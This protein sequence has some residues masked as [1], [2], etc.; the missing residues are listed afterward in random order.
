MSG[1]LKQ[2]FR[3][4]E[5]F[6]PYKRRVFEGEY[7]N[8]IAFPIGGI[9]TGCISLS[10]RGEL[11]DWEIF[12]RPNKNYRPRHTFFSLWAGR[13]GE[14]PVFRVLE[15]QL[16][17]AWSRHLMKHDAD[18]SPHHGYS[19][20]LARMSAAKF[21]GEFP[22]ALVEFEDKKVPLR[23]TLEV[24][25][26]FIPHNDR[27]SSL[28]VA[29]FFITLKNKGSKEV[30]ATVAL[31]VENMIGYQTPCCVD[32]RKISRPRPGLCVNRFR[33][34]KGLCGISMESRKF[35]PE[36]PQFGNLALGTSWKNVA[37]QA[38]WLR[39]AWFHG[40]THFCNTFVRTG[41]FDNNNE[42]SPSAENTTDIVS[43]GLRM[44]LASG[45][46]ARLPFILAWYFPRFE[47]YWKT[48]LYK[49]SCD[50]EP[51]G[52]RNYYATIFKDSWD[53][54]TYCVKNLK[55]LHD[56]SKEFSHALYN[57]TIPACAL[58]SVADN[59]SI[60]KTPTCVRLEDGSFYG[61]EGC[62]AGSGC[63]EGTCTHV[64][65]YA[66]ALP[67]LFPRLERTLRE[68]ELRY[69]VRMEDGHMQFRMPLPPGSPALHNFHAAVDGQL[70][71]VLKL[72]REYLLCGD[73]KWLSLWWQRARRA[74]E[75]ALKTWDADHDGLIEGLHHNTYDIEFVSA[76]PLACSFYLAA[77]R[78]ASE[79]A[80]HFGDESSAAE[81]RRL[82]ESGSRK[83][84]AELF[85]GEYYCQKLEDINRVK[86]QFGAGC[87]SDQMIGQWYADM[88]SLGNLTNPA[89]IRKALRSI[90]KYNWRDFT[91]F[92]NPQRVFAMNNEKGLVL[93]SWPHGGR[94][95]FPFPYSDEVWCGIEYQVACTMI[96]HGFP[97]E[98]LS[99]LK[100][101]RE[102]YN[103]HNRNPWNEVECGNHYARSL[104]SYALLQVL[105]GFQYS[106]PARRIRF[107]PRLNQSRFRCLFS[108]NDA[109]GEFQQCS[110]PKGLWEITLSLHAGVLEL[111]EVVLG[112]TGEFT[113]LYCRMRGQFI[114]AEKR[115]LQGGVA[116]MFEEDV[117]LSGG[118]PL[119]IRLSR[120]EPV[121]P[122]RV[123]GCR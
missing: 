7:L 90:Y 5:L 82:F 53:V 14:E 97:K 45:E 75:Y 10:G 66:Q 113:A 39:G 114:P 31:N 93:C 74:L 100:G 94:P 9:G 59:L 24:F 61:F 99:I 22:F 73:E 21:T 83:M 44:R 28:P 29:I 88:L 70:G 63:C 77:L 95:R 60:L 55:R 112:I 48:G 120:P 91:D 50:S 67:C 15:A 76:E 98:G 19:A 30:E 92:Q 51:P 80:A 1:K 117:R 4:D 35:Q 89:H 25:N 33:K 107:A 111:R 101:V 27:D 37:Y 8:E 64:W 87:L 109:W 71:T 121:C 52:W 123:G 106:A 119:A 3:K 46:E 102:R 72:Y 18:A 36:S 6:A 40:L 2:V 78:A 54:L 69:S 13:D 68:N 49:D 58:N 56:E 57:S 122:S 81:Y 104:A 41:R 108:V 110:D 116:I 34:E 79:M 105:S 11:V 118:E 115:C 85:N 62:N 17:P 38:P 96:S 26:P 47:R 84:D 12:N 43:L 20:G 86:Y 42:T 16:S 32:G 103:G 65:N 23:V